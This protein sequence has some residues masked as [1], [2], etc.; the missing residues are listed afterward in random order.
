VHQSTIDE[1][2]A[3]FAPFGQVSITDW[4]GRVIVPGRRHDRGVLVVTR[5]AG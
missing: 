2:E 4:A 5:R 1:F 3:L